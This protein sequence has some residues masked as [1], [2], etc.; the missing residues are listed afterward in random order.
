MSGCYWLRKFT[1]RGFLIGCLIWFGLTLGQQD[2]H[3]SYDQPER[4][5]AYEVADNHVRPPNYNGDHLTNLK[6]KDPCESAQSREDRD[7]CQQWRMAQ[8]AESQAGWTEA[9]FWITLAEVIGLLLVVIYTA[10]TARDAGRNAAAA[11][12]IVKVSQE[13]AERQLRAYVH[14]ESIALEYIKESREW[15]VIATI[16]NHGLTP[17]KRCRIRIGVNYGTA[18]I[19]MRFCAS[20]AIASRPLGSIP[21]S[22][23]TDHSMTVVENN[24]WDSFV[25]GRMEMYAWGRIEYEDVSGKARAT[26]FRMKKAYGPIKSFSLCSYGNYHT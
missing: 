14:V 12:A 23:R 15:M 1:L 4:Q 13:T 11:E 19:D 18:Q 9:Q 22:G 21:P 7:L 3:A 26:W 2:C 8:A 25:K 6:S 20:R 16:K 17:A 10:K 24:A 5:V